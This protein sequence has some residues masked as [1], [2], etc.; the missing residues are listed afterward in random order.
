MFTMEMENKLKIIIT[1]YRKRMYKKEEGKPRSDC[2]LMER[3]FRSAAAILVLIEGIE[4]TDPTGE[5]HGLLLKEL[6]HN[7]SVHMVY[8]LDVFGSSL[9]G[10]FDTT[11]GFFYSVLR[12]AF[13][14]EPYNRLAVFILALY[15]SQV[16]DGVKLEAVSKHF[17]QGGHSLEIKAFGKSGKIKDVYH[18]AA[19]TKTA[20]RDLEHYDKEERQINVI[21]RTL[22]EGHKASDEAKALA[23]QY[24]YELAPN[25]TF[26]RPF[27]K[28]VFVRKTG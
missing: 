15:A 4:I 8:K 13:D 28:Q 20:H 26:V 27:I 24:G 21:I 16:L 11:S 18:R 10:Y 6:V 2:I 17:L 14:L 19:A 3:T 1:K 22:P 12:E 23:E 25:Q 7:G 5:L 9:S